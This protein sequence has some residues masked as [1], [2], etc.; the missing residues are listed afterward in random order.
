[1]GTSC[2][3]PA[4]IISIYIKCCAARPSPDERSLFAFVK[5]PF[6]SARGGTPPFIFL[7][8]NFFST[9]NLFRFLLCTVFI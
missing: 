9:V 4:L 5:L 2:A 7:M 8:L 3:L 6:I 1:M